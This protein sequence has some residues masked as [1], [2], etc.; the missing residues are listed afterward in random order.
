LP[1]LAL[2]SARSAASRSSS[3]W[4]AAGPL[5]AAVEHQVADADVFR[6]D[7][8]DAQHAGE[9]AALEFAADGAKDDVVLGG[10][11]ARMEVTRLG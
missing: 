3:N 7:D 6:G 8:M 10:E 11:R 2:R 4:R 9:V 1:N 5:E